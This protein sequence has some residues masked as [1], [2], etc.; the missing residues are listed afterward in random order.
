MFHDLH[1]LRFISGAEHMVPWN[2]DGCEGGLH[3]IP[4]KPSL[5][6]SSP[7][8]T[9]SVVAPYAAAEP[10]LFFPLSRLPANTTGFC[11]IASITVIK[12]EPQGRRWRRHIQIGRL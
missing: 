8:R 7:R 2:Q 9:G 11:F 1:P 5:Q 4:S 6:R 12:A 10:P 3:E